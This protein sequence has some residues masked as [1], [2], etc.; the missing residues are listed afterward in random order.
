MSNS[1]RSREPE[2]LV[3]TAPELAKLLDISVRHLWACH[4]SGSLGPR[5]I[6]L[7]RSKR[8][9]I[10]EL[11]AWL[12]AGAPPR[13]EWDRMKKRGPGH[14]DGQQHTEDNRG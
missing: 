2:S 3:L 4:A 8:W 14:V 12:E 7:G 5:P 11:R 9:R 1:L 6:A 13:D 10:S